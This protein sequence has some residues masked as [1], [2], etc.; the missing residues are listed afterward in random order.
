[1]YNLFWNKKSRSSQF[2][3]LQE[4][5]GIVSF[6]LEL[7]E[8][9]DGVETMTEFLQSNQDRD[10]DKGSRQDQGEFRGREDKVEQCQ[11]LL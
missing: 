6:G 9:F 4:N 7:L 8:L 11:A 2:L 10:R 5:G 1:M 3:N